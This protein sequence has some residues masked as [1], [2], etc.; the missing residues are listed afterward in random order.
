M[1]PRDFY[2]QFSQHQQQAWQNQQQRPDYKFTSKT[3]EDLHDGWA[4]EDHL[5]ITKP[6]RKL[7]ERD[8]VNFQIYS[9]PDGRH[10]LIVTISRI[11]C[12]ECFEVEEL[13]KLSDKKTAKGYTDKERRDDVLNHLY[14]YMI[15]NALIPYPVEIYDL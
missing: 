15:N 2:F 14:H 5:K 8:D 10:W 3:A 4:Q 11:E 13:L 1:N 7:F 6:G 12:A 9:K